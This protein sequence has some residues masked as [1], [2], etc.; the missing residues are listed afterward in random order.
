ML[1]AGGGAAVWAQSAR[2]ED[3][4]KGAGRKPLC[5]GAFGGAAKLAKPAAICQESAVKTFGGR[6]GV[7]E[8]AEGLMKKMVRAASRRETLY[9]Q[10]AAK[11][12][13][14]PLGETATVVDDILK[15]EVSRMPT[16]AQE[17]ILKSSRRCREFYHADHGK[18]E[19]AIPYF[20]TRRR[21]LG[22]YSPLERGGEKSVWRQ[23][24]K[25]GLRQHD[26]PH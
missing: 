15:N 11:G 19:N 13:H 4:L 12:V 17:E 21:F 5:K 18:D 16:E 14:V 1:A 6:A 23:K 9:K 22:G 20:T 26:K 25:F 7:S 24:S 10:A 2:A 3:P 8:A